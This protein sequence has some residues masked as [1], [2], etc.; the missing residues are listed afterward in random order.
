[1]ELNKKE[2]IL[3]DVK[4]T[5]NKIYKKYKEIGINSI[6]LWGSIISEDF[7]PNKSDVDS[8]AIVNNEMPLSYEDK[9]IKEI[10]DLQPKIKD[11]KIRFVYL[12]ELNDNIQRG[13]LTKYVSPR[14]L[15][16]NLK[17]WH[18]VCGKKQL[19]SDFKVDTNLNKITKEKR[20]EIKNKFEEI[21]TGKAKDGQYFGKAV[22]RLIYYTEQSRNQFPYSQT[23]L[24]KHTSP[25]NKEIVKKLIKIKNDKWNLSQLKKEFKDLDKIL[26]KIA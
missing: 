9:I 21:R 6:Y 13:N 15:L 5:L 16:W 24:L 10:K 22:L 1:M 2:T 7:D 25:E 3:K 18:L 26:E 20:V 12:E 19:A 4:K 23:N 11:F 8:V 17:Y 14:Q